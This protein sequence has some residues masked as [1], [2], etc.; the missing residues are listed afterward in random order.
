MNAVIY[1]NFYIRFMEKI[2]SLKPT[3]IYQPVK[4]Y[5]KEKTDFLIKDLSNKKNK[6]ACILSL[7]GTAM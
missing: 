7:W 6:Y 1:F 2:F 5:S 3:K 4:F